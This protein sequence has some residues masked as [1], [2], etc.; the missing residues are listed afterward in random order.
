MLRTSYKV[1]YLNKWLS[2]VSS[3][4]TVTLFL[5]YLV[6]DLV[7]KGSTVTSCNSVTYLIRS[8]KFPDFA[9]PVHETISYETI[10]RPGS[11]NPDLST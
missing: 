8:T 4:V 5:M 3:L 6:R 1:C 2:F 10:S 11:V 7:G 9:N